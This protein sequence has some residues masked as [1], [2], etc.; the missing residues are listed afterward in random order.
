MYLK[1]IFVTIYYNMDDFI[2]SST[3]GTCYFYGLKSSSITNVSNIWSHLKY[4]DINE[5][6]NAIGETS[7]VPFYVCFINYFHS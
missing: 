7:N 2:L 4:C 1:Y 3:S 5:I 6:T